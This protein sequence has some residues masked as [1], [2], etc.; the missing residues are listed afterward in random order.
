MRQVLSAPCVTKIS[1][2]GSH[3]TPCDMDMGKMGVVCI[4]EPGKQGRLRYLH[5][6]LMILEPAAALPALHIPQESNAFD[7]ARQQ[8][9]A[10]RRP[11]QVVYIF[12][13]APERGGVLPALS[14]AFSGL[15]VP[16]SLDVSGG[17][18]WSPKEKLPPGSAR[19]QQASIGGEADT[20]DGLRVVSQAAY[21]FHSR[22][23]LFPQN[24]LIPSPK[25]ASQ[26]L[27]CQR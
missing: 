10:V 3:A 27:I 22:A 1:P 18:F 23:P 17:C 24:Y 13:V 11:R 12:V 19:S 5:V 4:E 8:S 7:G 9:R 6:S 16:R 14:I 2:R 25:G 15:E 26:G 21:R 20:V